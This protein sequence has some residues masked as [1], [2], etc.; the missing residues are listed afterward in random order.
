M[1][2]CLVVTAAA[3][4]GGEAGPYCFVDPVAVG[5]SN[6]AFEIESEPARRSGEWARCSHTGQSRPSTRRQAA[7]RMRRSS[8]KC[9]RNEQARVLRDRGAATS[10]CRASPPGEGLLRTSRFRTSL[11]PCG[12]E[13]VS[14]SFSF[15]DSAYDP[16]ATAN[17]EWPCSHRHVSCDKLD[18]I[19]AMRMR[20]V[21]REAIRA[22][23]EK[24]EVVCANCHPARTHTR[25]TGVDIRARRSWR[26]LASVTSRCWPTR[27]SSGGEGRTRD[28]WSKG[29]TLP[30]AAL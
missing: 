3:L 25:R 12:R 6:A 4:V 5:E 28:E 19:C 23:I 9:Q 14:R 27:T 26:P 16:L 21:S 8:R 2:S 30:L 13:S 11:A 29:P 15:P 17:P 20:T 22:K 7:W 10:L 24:C 1:T 18:D